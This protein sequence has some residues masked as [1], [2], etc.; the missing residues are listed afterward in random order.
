M[1]AWKATIETVL[2]GI[3]FLSVFFFLDLLTNLSQKGYRDDPVQI[4]HSIF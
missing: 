2:T 4:S 3:N 1:E